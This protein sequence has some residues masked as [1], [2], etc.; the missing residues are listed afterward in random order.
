MSALTLTACSDLTKLSLMKRKNCSKS[1]Q[2]DMYPKDIRTDPVG[3][4]S[5]RSTL[6]PHS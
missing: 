6:S 3:V 4:A 5:M 2:V 1:S